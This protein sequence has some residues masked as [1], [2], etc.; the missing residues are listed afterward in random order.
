MEVEQSH[1]TPGKRKQSDL[2][3]LFSDH[4]LQRDRGRAVPLL[5]PRWHRSLC[6]LN[7]YLFPSCKCQT[8]AGRLNRWALPT[9]TYLTF[10]FCFKHLYLSF[11]PTSTVVST[12]L[13]GSGHNHLNMDACANM[14]NTNIPF[15]D[16]NSLT[17]CDGSPEPQA[18][19]LEIPAAPD[20][21]QVW[22]CAPTCRWHTGNM[23][24][25]SHVINIS[26]LFHGHFGLPSEDVRSLPVSCFSSRFA[27]MNR[28]V[29]DVF[30]TQASRDFKG[31]VPRLDP[32]FTS[33]LLPG[34]DITLGWCEAI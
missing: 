5:P 31:F 24:W 32:H 13:P 17:G 8:H 25:I 23:I 33:V 2:C 7:C 20:A 16:D 12:V 28:K 29:L 3:T 34:A 18:Y 11:S 9:R 22:L 19:I 27:L 4:V 30:G 10:R 14:L 1:V 21:G 15:S 6:H 26:H